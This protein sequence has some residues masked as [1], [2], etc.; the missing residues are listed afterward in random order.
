MNSPFN[1]KQ[2][3]EHASD[4]SSEPA[5]VADPVP[6]ALHENAD[7]PIVE[8][9]NDAWR[10]TQRGSRLT[11]V[12]T[13]LIRKTDKIMAIGSCFALEI[14]QALKA[15]GFGVYPRYAD[16]DFDPETQKLAK[17]PRK[18]DI[19]HF[20]TF[21]IRTEFE[22][23]LAGSHFQTRDFV[24]YAANGQKLFERPSDEIWEDPYR[25]DIYAASEAAIIDLSRKIDTCI[26][27]A[28]LQA[29]VHV[30]TLGL[31][32][33]WRNDNNGQVVNYVPNRER[34]GTAPGFTFEQSTYEQNYENMR[35]VCS[36]LQEQSPHKKVIL[37]VSPV[38]LSRTF[39][40]T[41]IVVANM[42]SKSTLRAVAGVIAREF[43]NVTYWPS[44]EM[45]VT[46]D[47]FKPD[48]RHVT[49]EGVRT[50]VE[51][52]LKVHLAA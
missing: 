3:D 8:A 21:T 32:E 39:S 31:T 47:I 24:G 43:N 48:G 44:Y 10:R 40:G 28:V 12:R 34:D 11:F 4:M 42:E 23:A 18:D 6:Q 19:S 15:L 25:K 22:H 45:A 30:I 20:N 51:Q 27:K 9:Y 50:I 7:F 37:T 41:D 2:A 13:P 1:V 52:F 33:V 46:R 38:A 36:M 5:P 17:L 16:V 35:V 49:P 29:D 14:R 26:R